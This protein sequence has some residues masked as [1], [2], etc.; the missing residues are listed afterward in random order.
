MQS[1]PAH[2]VV[3]FALAPVTGRLGEPGAIER[4]LTQ[5]KQLDPN[6]GCV[7]FN[8]GDSGDIP[9]VD[10]LVKVVGVNNVF[11]LRYNFRLIH[12]SL[13]YQKL[14][15]WL[16]EKGIGATG[17]IPQPA[18]TCPAAPAIATP[19]EATSQVLQP[20]AAQPS[21]PEEAI[22]PAAQ[23]GISIEERLKTTKSFNDQELRTLLK[24]L[25]DQEIS[26]LWEKI[27][28]TYNPSDLQYSYVK[29]ELNQRQKKLTSTIPS[30]PATTYPATPT[31]AIPTI[32]AKISQPTAPAQAI[33]PI[34][35]AGLTTERIAQLSTLTDQELRTLNDQELIT[36]IKDLARV[37]RDQRTREWGMALNKIHKEKVAR[38]I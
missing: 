4:K 3:L 29:S 2:R 37:P 12:D 34:P 30:K 26:N 13:D 14:I 25:T 11:Q 19:E 24:E 1:L 28:K 23:A 8:F 18:V 32:P 38:K 16:K 17:Y 20:A 36:L 5:L 35:A 10:D 22:Q 6:I 33:Q 9:D 21:A 7:V 15:D 31:T 27:K